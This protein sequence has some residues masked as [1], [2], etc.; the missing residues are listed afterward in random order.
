MSNSYI[1][2]A[3][4]VLADLN[5]MY[6]K[7]HNYHWYVKGPHFFG[8]HTKFEEL[9]D[10]TTQHMDMVAERLLTINE[11]PLATMADYLKVA[12]IKEATGNENA[13]MM[14]H[15][16]EADLQ[17]LA[18]EMLAVAMKADK[19]GDRLTVS[20]FEGMADSFHKHAWM[21]RASMEK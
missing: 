10:E 17:H 2:K 19:A 16:V 6:V 8:L 18:A 4:V 13:E 5:V 7:L 3:N 20:L 14:A 15:N 21:L 12:T 1:E 11:K 9:Y